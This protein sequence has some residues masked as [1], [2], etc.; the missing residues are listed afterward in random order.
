MRKGYFVTGTDTEIGKTTIACGLV[1]AMRAKDRKVAVMKP[2]ASGCT[3][4][5]NG[6]RNAD[7][8]ALIA[9]SGGSWEYARVNP[10]AFEPPIAP[11]IAASDAGVEISADVI[12]SAFDNLK[13]QSD[14][15]VVEGVGGFRVPLGDAF[16]TADLALRLALPVIVVVGLRLGCINHALL[17]AEAVLARGLEFAGWIGNSPGPGMD[18]KDANIEALARRLPGPCLG[19]V[20]SFP[21]PAPARVASALHGNFD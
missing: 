11:H 8:E 16:D 13:R 4:T 2:V 1:H 21:E 18:A 12:L 20:P 17:T 15:I 14:C 7:A 6:L 5:A 10:Y 9:A 19:L 3:R